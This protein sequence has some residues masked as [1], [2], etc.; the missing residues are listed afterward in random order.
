MTHPNDDLRAKEAFDIF[1]H[2]LMSQK[3]LLAYNNPHNLPV[4]GDFEGAV[5]LGFKAAWN[6]RAKDEAKGGEAV[7]CLDYTTI[8]VPLVTWFKQMRPGKYDVYTSPRPTADDAR[9]AA[10]Y[11]WVKAIGCSGDEIRYR[12]LVL[13]STPPESLDQAIDA[14]MAE[15]EEK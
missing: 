13:E 1:F 9:D 14:A 15:R 12:L 2:D 10:R 4:D 5:R 3:N 8:G 7:A 6:A 11:R